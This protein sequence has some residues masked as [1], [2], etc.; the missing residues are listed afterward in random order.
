[1]PAGVHE[2]AAST[3]EAVSYTC[4]MPKT[5]DSIPSHVVVHGAKSVLPARL[6]MTFSFARSTLLHSDC[7]AAARL[8]YG[9]TMHDATST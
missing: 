8:Y 3:F 1:M 9:K 5:V 6:R 4:L 2:E 7:S